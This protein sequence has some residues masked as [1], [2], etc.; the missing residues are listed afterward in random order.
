LYSF[1]PP[2]LRRS[3]GSGNC[4][5]LKLIGEQKTTHVQQV[6]IEYLHRS[7]A[8]RVIE[9]ISISHSLKQNRVQWLF[10]SG[11]FWNDQP[12]AYNGYGCIPPSPQR[13]EGRCNTL[14]LDRGTKFSQKW[15]DFEGFFALDGF[16]TINHTRTTGPVVFL[17]RS[18]ATKVI[19]GISQ[20]LLAKA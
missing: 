15:F 8:T 14:K 19:E 18:G 10:G 1:I 12:H 11:R 16:G 20:S 13:Y 7:G 4:N 6:L 3:L 9:G 17:H 5:V 2:V